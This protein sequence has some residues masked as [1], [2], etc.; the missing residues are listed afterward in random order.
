MPKRSVNEIE[1]GYQI[2][3]R[4]TVDGGHGGGGGAGRHG[5]QRRETLVLVH[6]LGCAKEMWAPQVE[7]FSQKYRVVT[8]DNRGV[9]ESTVTDG[10]YSSKQM[11]GDLAGLV[12][13]LDIEKFHL[14]GMSLGGMIAQEYAIA[15]S[16]RLLSLSLCCTYAAPGPFCSRIFDGWRE[17]VPALGT[18]YA[19]REILRWA[20]TT[21]FFEENEETVCQLEAMMSANPPAVAGYLG[22]LQAALDHD[23]RGRL[24]TISCPAMTLVGAQDRLIYPGLSHQMYDELTYVRWAEVPGGHAC[25][26]ENP[27]AFNHTVLDFLASADL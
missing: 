13:A 1:L 12:D 8:I 22:Q 26:W 5:G 18:A 10:A 2:E 15:H 3:D 20:F 9:G 27:E 19:Q 7:A 4:G 25:L 16:D 24:D 6:G 14:L 23:T 17:A 11:A 21:A